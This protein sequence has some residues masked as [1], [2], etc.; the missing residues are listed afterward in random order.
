MEKDGFSI[1]SG[2]YKVEDSPYGKTHTYNFVFARLKQRWRL[3]GP[4]QL[5]ALDN[6]F[7]IVCFVLEE[8]LLY[9]LTEGPWVVA[10]Q[11]VSVKKRRPDKAMYRGVLVKVQAKPSAWKSQLL[12]IARRITLIQSVA[13]SMS[14]YTMQTAKLP[15]ALCEDLDKSSKSLGRGWC[16]KPQ[17]MQLIRC[18]HVPT[19]ML[20]WAKPQ[21]SCFLID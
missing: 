1:E 19:N 14:L 16:T 10:G 8:D 18:R 15:Q 20:T 5:V 3:K 13:S 9:V 11:Y 21:A 2:D 12:S 4:T 17:C 7:F 6:G